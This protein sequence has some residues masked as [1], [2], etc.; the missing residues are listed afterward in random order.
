MATGRPEDVEQALRKAGM[1]VTPQRLAIA[2]LLRGSKAHPSPEMVYSDLK[3]EYPGLSLN[4]VYQTL[5]TLE[6]AGLLRRISMEENVHRYDANTAPHAHLV[7]RSCGRVD[8]ADESV[9]PLLLD[10]WQKEADLSK[11]DIHAMDCVFFGLCP[12]CART[13]QTVHKDDQNEEE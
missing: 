13:R 6:D 8:D 2:G 4:T 11:W 10:L 1:R 3:P 5:H 7:C 9:D 12:E